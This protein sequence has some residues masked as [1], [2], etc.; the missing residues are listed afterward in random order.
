MRRLRA[1]SVLLLA[2][3]LPASGLKNRLLN[4]LG[5]EIH[6][7]ARIQ[8][9]YLRGVQKFKVGANSIVRSGNQ[10]RNLRAVLIGDNT[11]VG[12]WNQIWA[13]TRFRDA[14]N[15]EPEWVGVFSIGNSA[16]ITR[17]HNLDATGG[18]VLADWSGLGGRGT[19][20]LSH[21]YDPRTH[22]MLCLP[23]R[24]EESAFVAAQC[25]VAMGATVPAR[26]VMAMGALMMPGAKEEY[27]IYAGI[28]AKVIKSGIEDWKCFD[29][30]ADG[31]HVRTP[32]NPLPA[33][34]HNRPRI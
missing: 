2:L 34:P 28:P 9:I 3:V 23:T 29:Y 15:A 16:L 5:A 1:L 6:P 18:L 31:T 17:R 33:Y 27:A 4:L 20:M 11:L 26:S 19:T 30:G 7:T 25:T 22:L 12:P 32:T 10:F 8:R 13:N 21:S 24:I 14:E